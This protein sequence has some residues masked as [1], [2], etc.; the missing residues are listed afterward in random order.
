MSLTQIEQYQVLYS[1]NKFVPRIAIKSG[2]KYIGQLIFYD[3]GATLPDDTI[4]NG[5]VHLY[6]HLEDFPN[7]IDLLRNEEPVF[8][9]YSGSGP[10]FENAITTAAEP[11]GEGEL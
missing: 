3:S 1:S 8:L 9:L 10:E 6:Y 2:N 7:I 4:L 11:I 5:E